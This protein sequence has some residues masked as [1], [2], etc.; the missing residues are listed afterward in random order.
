MLINNRYFRMSL[1]CI[2]SKDIKVIMH[3]KRHNE[4]SY[5]SEVY[6]PLEF[7]KSFRPKLD[8][9]EIKLPDDLSKY[10][11]VHFSPRK[12][13]TEDVKISFTTNDL[14]FLNERSYI[15]FSIFLSAYTTN[16]HLNS[17]I[18][19]FNEFFANNGLADF[20][21]ANLTIKDNGKSLVD[22]YDFTNFYYNKISINF[23]KK[24][25]IEYIVFGIVNRVENC[26]ISLLTSP[27]MPFKL[28]NFKEG[29]SGLMFGNIYINSVIAEEITNSFFDSH[30]S[31]KYV[32]C[33]FEQESERLVIFNQ[34]DIDSENK[35]IRVDLYFNGCNIDFLNVRLNKL[36]NVETFSLEHSNIKELIISK[37]GY[38]R[39]THLKLNESS[40]NNMI[41]D[42]QFLVGNCR[43]S[44][45]TIGSLN[46]D[47]FSLAFEKKFPVKPVEL[48]D[49][50]LLVL[51]RSIKEKKKDFIESVKENIKKISNEYANFF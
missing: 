33:F 2:N 36:S 23:Y 21:T 32:L 31:Y 28:S 15:D 20:K 12:K 6:D 48:E 10:F 34:S 40:I 4:D 29:F 49:N 3:T 44:L 14:I 51:K 18:R 17:I 47:N 7:D 5:I 50:L 8:Y 27:N 41:S 25:N 43:K 26:N 39:K 11:I 37:N 24:Y 22:C 9:L 13:Y 35:K 1:D 19:N 16:N 46:L 38:G 30:L 45:L 42:N